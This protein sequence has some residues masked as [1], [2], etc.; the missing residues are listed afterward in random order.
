MAASVPAEPADNTL[1]AMS[2]CGVHARDLL[3]AAKAIYAADKAN[4]ACHL[5][6]LALEE[7][8]GES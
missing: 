1:E 5:A 8:G 6:T 4:I 3:D 2:A 7:R